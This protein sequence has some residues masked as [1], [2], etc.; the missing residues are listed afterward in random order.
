MKFFDPLVFAPSMFSLASTVVVE[1]L[2]VKKF[3]KSRYGMEHRVH[4]VP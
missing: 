4:R 1:R 3:Q 2:T